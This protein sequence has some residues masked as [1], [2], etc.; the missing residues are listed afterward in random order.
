MPYFSR[1]VDQPTAKS[2]LW[3]ADLQFLALL[4]EVVILGLFA[5]MYLKKRDEVTRV[6]GVILEKRVNSYQEILAFFE[7]ATHS[8][9]SAERSGG[10]P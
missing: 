6:A 5:S 1:A 4:L 10:A 2:L 7:D 8:A 3:E 9:T